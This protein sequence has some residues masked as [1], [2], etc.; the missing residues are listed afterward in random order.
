MMTI[1]LYILGLLIGL[2]LALFLLGISIVIVA[3][4]SFNIVYLAICVWLL[5]ITE[6]IKLFNKSFD[7]DG[8]REKIERKV[9]NFGEKYGLNMDDSY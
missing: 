7:A 9:Y 2:P 8:Y 3:L 1:I 4:I 5:L 6:V